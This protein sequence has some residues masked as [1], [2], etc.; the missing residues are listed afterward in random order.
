MRLRSVLLALV[1]AVSVATPAQAAEACSRFERQVYGITAEGGLVEHGFCLDPERTTFSRW[2]DERVVAASGWGDVT[3]VFWSGNVYEDGVY[4][5]VAGQ[6]LFWSKDLQSWH[7]LRRGTDWSRFTS[8][9]STEP[10]VLYGTEASGAVRRFAHVGWQDGL[11]RWGDDSRQAE[12]PAGAGCSA[13]PAA[14]SW[15]WTVPGPRTS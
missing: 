3:A 9:I 15:V 13:T 10:G 6:G 2:G 11:D 12:L 5:R 1:M 4:Y 14:G 7:Q 8:L